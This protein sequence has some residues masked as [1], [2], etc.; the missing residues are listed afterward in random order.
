MELPLIKIL[1]LEDYV[2]DAE[3]IELELQEA[4]LNFIIKKTETKDD[5]LKILKDFFPDI[6]LADYK[7]PHWT[8]IEALKLLKENTFD[9]PC[10]LVTGNQTEEIAVETMKLGAVDYILKDS[11]K[12]LPNAIKNAL[13]H[14]EAEKAK[15]KAEEALRDEYTFRKTIE[16]TM[17]AG[18]AVF[19]SNLTQTYV[20]AAFCKIVERSKEE[21]LGSKPPYIYWPENQKEEMLN[22]L[23]DQMKK[24]DSSFQYETKYITKSGKLFDVQI[25]SSSMR[26]CKGNISGWVMVVNDISEQKQKEI[27]INYSLKEKEL[28]LKEIHHRVK[29]NMQ[30]VSSLLSLQAG[31]LID[32]KMQE[33]FNESRNRIKALALIHEYLYKT[34][35]FTKINFANYITDIVNNLFLTYRL[36]FK[37]CEFLLRLD[38]IDFDIDTSINLGIIINEL[39]SNSIKH[40]FKT[41]T[42]SKNIITIKL[43]KENN[44]IS[45]TVSDNGTGIQDKKKFL[46]SDSL[47]LQLVKTLVDQLEGT[48]DI[49]SKKGME[50][51]INFNYEFNIKCARSEYLN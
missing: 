3:L 39:V 37:E 45:I 40:A 51:T 17:L 22:Y 7:M 5:F 43:T 2:S 18:V 19:D 15:V 35:E 4:G 36:D 6:I 25:L 12:R 49:R 44:R 41:S 50:I 29:N 31:Y 24:R 21:L 47:G 23:F 28:L 14:K 1:L 8:A 48:F 32:N 38:D 27:Q 33:V 42:S 26:D 20:N 11:L 30:I 46:N 34:K 10:I 13:K 9:I 16:D